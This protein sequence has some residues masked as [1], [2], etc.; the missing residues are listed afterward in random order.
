MHVVEGIGS[1]ADAGRFKKRAPVP[2]AVEP[3]EE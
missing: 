3:I 2:V 1:L